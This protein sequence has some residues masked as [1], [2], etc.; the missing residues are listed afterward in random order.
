MPP[1]AGGQIV[2]PVSGT[3]VRFVLG[4]HSGSTASTVSFQVIGSPDG[5]ATFA[6]TGT[7]SPAPAPMPTTTAVTEFPAHLPIQAGDYIAVEFAGATALYAL[8]PQPGA[9]F[10][11]F[12]PALMDGGASESPTRTLN[13]NATLLFAADVALPPTSNA[14]VPSCSPSGAIAATVTTDPDPAVA[15]AA[16]HFRFDAGAEQTIATA[17]NPGTATIAVP[18][19]SHTLQYWGA[20]TVGGI[21]NTHHTASVMVDSIPP[22]VSIASDQG[23]TTYA[24][25]DVASITVTASDS[26][27]GL[28]TDPSGASEL[29]PTSVPGTFTLS[30]TAVD[31]CGN[32]T[33]ASFT[34]N[35][36]NPGTISSLAHL[37]GLGTHPRAFI[38]ASH[39]GSIARATGTKITYTDS[40]RATTTFTTLRPQPGVLHGGKCVKPRPGHSHRKHCTRYLKIGSF[41]HLDLVGKNRFQFTGR[42]NRRKLAPGSYRLQ[43][44]ARGANGKPGPPAFTTFRILAG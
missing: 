10:A 43:A 25:G 4:T 28:Q 34:Y 9:R 32:A 30:R 3:V 19:G 24:D 18:N 36:T 2:S 42:I 29:L 5:G 7:T 13:V 37:T 23:K 20:D 27:S 6:S 44:V 1:S 35:V 38:A 15:P 39:G 8:A 26:G 12:M 31:R 11:E 21:E 40:Q 14:Q 33:T 16:V 41:H 17:G 22:V